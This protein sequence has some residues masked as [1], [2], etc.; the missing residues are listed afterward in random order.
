MS[1]TITADTSTQ[2]QTVG[3]VN[4]MDSLAKQNGRTIAE[5]PKTRRG[6]AALRA[7]KKE[8]EFNEVFLVTFT[9]A[10]RQR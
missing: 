4:Q 3:T 2:T 1:E 6:N 7:E 9:A 10:S 5:Q 8:L